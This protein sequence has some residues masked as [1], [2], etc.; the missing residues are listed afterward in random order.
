MV[1]KYDLTLY[2]SLLEIFCRQKEKDKQML[3]LALF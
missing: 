1:K 2:A 3:I